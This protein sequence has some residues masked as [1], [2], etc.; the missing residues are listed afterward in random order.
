MPR[1]KLK[2]GIIAACVAL[3]FGSGFGQ[4]ILS[5]R[6]PLGLPVNP[7]SAT[8]LNM[9]GAATAA[10]ID[11]HIHLANPANLGSIDK[12]A[13]TS[14]ASFNI[15]QLNQAGK[16]AILTRFHPRQIGF[17]FPM[18]VGGTIGLSLSKETDNILSYEDKLPVTD[19]TRGAE[20]MY[21]QDGGLTA[22][23]AAWGRSVTNWLH[24]GL[25]YKRL[26]LVMTNVTATEITFD[27]QSTSSAL[28]STRFEFSGHAIRLGIMAPLGAL[29]LGISADYALEGTLQS[30]SL[31]RYSNPNEAFKTLGD[32][33]K[34]SEQ[35]QLPLTVSVGAS[36]EFSPKWLTTADLSVTNWDMYQSDLLPSA[37]LRANAVSVG[38]G[39]RFIPA[40]DLL[41]P[42]YWETIHIR[43]GL[44]YQ[45]LPAE[46]DGELSLA[47]GTGLPL[48]GGGLLDLV[49]EYTRR[50]TNAYDFGEDR[51]VFG[52]GVNGGRT[53]RKTGGDTY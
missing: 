3:G 31:I 53:W 19:T 1:Y 2:I 5:S 4:S 45:Q 13:L 27:D 43:A 7:G 50:T 22:W 11:H 28:D 49:A 10:M 32:T 48:R 17:A 8:A 46:G 20:R 12:T 34:Q 40:P 14:L 37:E 36:Y 21:S 47:L 16:T 24:V 23:Q 38:F 44:R 9:G 29:T 52:I 42:R 33:V 25:G 6:Y 51:F 18:G 35:L 41:A 39:G 30:D 15:L 26:Q